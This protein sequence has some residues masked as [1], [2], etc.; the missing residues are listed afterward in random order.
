MWKMWAF[1]SFSKVYSF[2]AQA[3]SEV[4]I[5]PDQDLILG[6][7]GFTTDRSET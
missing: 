7:T 3:M 5:V 4:E 1:G 2:F 6:L